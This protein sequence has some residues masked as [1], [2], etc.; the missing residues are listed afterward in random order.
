[1][2]GWARTV[3]AWGTVLAVTAVASERE[4]L[5]V[6]DLFW[7]DA[8]LKVLLPSRKSCILSEADLELT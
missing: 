5:P 1:M 6:P 7:A 2:R 8:R 4:P 3:C